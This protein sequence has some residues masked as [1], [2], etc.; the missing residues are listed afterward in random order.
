[1]KT[2]LFLICILLVGFAVQAQDSPIKIIKEINDDGSKN[3]SPANLFVYK[4][5]VYFA[6][7]DA[8]GSNTGDADLGK[9]LWETDG[10][11]AGTKLVKDL[12]AGDNNST[13]NNFFEYKNLMY[14][15]ASNGAV[16]NALFS[17]DGTAPNT[18]ATGGS[19]IFNPVVFNDIVYY[20]NTTDGNGLYQFDGTDQANVV[21]MGTGDESLVGGQFIVFGGKLLCYMSYSTDK[22]TKGLELYEY[23]PATDVFKLIKDITGDNKS[24]S[25]S[26]FTVLNNVVYFEALNALWK[27]DGTTAGTVAVEAAATASISDVKSLYAW[28]GALFFEGDDG[29][30]DQLWKHNPTDNTVTKLSNLTGTN[31]NHD[32]GDYA[33]TIDY[34]YYSAKDAEDTKVHLWRTDGGTTVEQLDN[35][36][37]DVDEIIILNNMLLFEGDNG[38]TGNELYGYILPDVSVT[39]ISVTGEMEMT[40]GDTQTLT[41]RVTPDHATDK[42]VTWSTN[43]E[44]IAT[45]DA[46]GVVNAVKVGNVNI[47][48]TASD[49]SGVTGTFSIS[50]NPIL[51]SAIVVNGKAEMTI[52]TTQT[53]TAA[54]TPNNA[55]NK[56]FTWSS[57]DGAIATVGASGVVNAVKVGNVNITATASDRSGVT[58]TFSISVNPILVSAI[59]VNGKEEMTAGDTQTLTAAITPNNAANKDFT[60]S[61]SDGAIA[62]VDMSGV[63][64]AVKVGNV[65][66]TATASDG[67]GVTGTFSIN[68]S[69][70]VLSGRELPLDIVIWPNP[71]SDLVHVDLGQTLLSLPFAMIASDGKTMLEG[72]LNNQTTLDLSAF[73]RGLYFLRVQKGYAY[74]FYKIV[75]Q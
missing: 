14:F 41:L 64:N 38:T 23:D 63:V 33:P 12:N 57:S 18:S 43:D 32:P 25:I 35:T 72:I 1:M 40:T 24:S 49:G 21:D 50:V 62:T 73:D 69:E 26:E 10:T 36:I 59:V 20:V 34:L 55:A 7:D 66:I 9:E 28:N 75:R 45:V 70:E 65:N 56:D 19:F 37:V 48:A 44:N 17:S 47:T 16:R 22:A 74:S 4:G 8:N 58:G 68:V 42:N 13:P 31:S 60:W 52:G 51:V 27:T 54:I 71:S 11:S 6:A 2:Y 46:S 5:K 67:S 3:S 29:S 61:S 30:G 15:S 39:S 53:L